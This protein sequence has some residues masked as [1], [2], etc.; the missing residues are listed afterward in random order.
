[1]GVLVNEVIKN[2]ASGYVAQL[3]FEALMQVRQD[4]LYVCPAPEQQT[5]FGDVAAIFISLAGM[6]PAGE[7]FEFEDEE[8]FEGSDGHAFD[9][10]SIGI[11]LIIP[12][13]QPIDL[14]DVDIELDIVQIHLVFG[15]SFG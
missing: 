8:V 2:G 5:D 14:F 6:S 4:Q 3:I 12:D 1:M 7:G 15:Q 9:Y 11:D 10:D 13:R